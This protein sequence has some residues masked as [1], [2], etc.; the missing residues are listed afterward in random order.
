MTL[1]ACDACCAVTC[2]T[3][4]V[5][6]FQFESPAWSYLTKQVPVPLV[7]VIVLAELEHAVAVVTLTTPPGAVA[8]T[9]KLVR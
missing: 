1:I 4:C 8:T 5:A 3:T 7:I 6:G 2:S 9:P